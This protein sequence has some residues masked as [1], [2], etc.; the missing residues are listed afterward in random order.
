M[1]VASTSFKDA[2][3]HVELLKTDVHVPG[4]EVSDFNRL[5]LGLGLGS[6]GRD[7]EEI[8]EGIEE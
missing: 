3:V 6:L 5:G 8:E 7:E 2:F 4:L 1:K